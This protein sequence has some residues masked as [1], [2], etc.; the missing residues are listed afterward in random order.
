MIYL[1]DLGNIVDEKVYEFYYDSI[2]IEN[3]L[4]IKR[5]EKADGYFI[6]YYDESEKLKIEYKIIGNMICPDAYTL[7]DVEVPFDL[8]EIEDVVTEME[9]EGIYLEKATK[10]IDIIKQI[11]LPI[12]PIKVAKNEKIEYSNKCDWSFSKEEDFVKEDPKL[13]DLKKLL[14]EEGNNGCSTK[15]K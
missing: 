4:F 6:F 13:K 7:E 1:K 3:N 14:D 12:V 5:I 10:K 11:I 15:K 2:E 9:N 8:E